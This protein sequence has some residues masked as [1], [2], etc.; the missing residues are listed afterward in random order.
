MP[1]LG[2]LFGH[3]NG[4]AVDIIDAV[5]VKFAP[6]RPA[7][8]AAAAAAEA[9]V[10]AA[11]A[12]G[13]E[14][15]A[16]PPG[17]GADDPDPRFDRAFLEKQREMYCKVYEH[18]E[19]LGWYTVGEAPTPVHLQLQRD[20]VQYNEAP[21]FLLMQPSPDPNA[22]E[23][24]VAIYESEMHMV[25]DAPTLLFVP[26]AFKL[27]T[28]QAERIMMEAVAQTAPPEG[29][30]ALEP[31]A[32]A[33]ENSLVTLEGRVAELVAYLEKVKAADAGAAVDYT[34]LRK[35]AA[36]CS[37]VGARSGAR[38]QEGR[39]S[40][41]TVRLVSVSLSCRARPLTR[42]SFRRSTRMSSRASSPTSTTI[43]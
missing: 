16:P 4:L 17:G 37:Q 41:L 9:A 43:H 32:A 38:G 29:T 20:M 8:A 30:S 33:V 24:P 34:M 27:E 7:D 18:R 12:A 21:L 36:L 39:T 19:V 11:A 3:Q 40:R 22:S 23:L 42:R 15:P 6:R 10:A 2:L 26:V 1:P 14:P 28:I 13:A 31:H 35:I 25:H 5:E